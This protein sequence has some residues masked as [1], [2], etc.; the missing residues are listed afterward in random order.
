LIT[1]DTLTRTAT[2]LGTVAPILQR[3]P[4]TLP[5]AKLAQSAVSACAAA[6]PRDDKILSEKV[7]ALK[8]ILRSLRRMN[9][10]GV[11]GNLEIL[12]RKDQSENTSSDSCT[13]CDSK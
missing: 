11:A 2:A 3:H 4:V 6:I 10:S 9:L 8:A 7:A 13:E 12:L 5:Y 1:V